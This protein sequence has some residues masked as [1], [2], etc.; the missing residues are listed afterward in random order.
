MHFRTTACATCRKLSTLL[1]S[2][3]NSSRGTEDQVRGFCTGASPGQAF[4]QR[5]HL[6]FKVTLET[7]TRGTEAW[8]AHVPA[9]LAGRVQ[10]GCTSVPGDVLSH[11]AEHQITAWTPRHVESHVF[12]CLPTTHGCWLPGSMNRTA[13]RVTSKLS[14]RFADILKSSDPSSFWSSLPRYF[15]KAARDH[16]KSQQQIAK[17][18]P[19]EVWF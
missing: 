5:P 7:Q 6:H 4:I 12:G 3:S 8:P 11:L 1:Q 10:A 18:S 17:P 15:T 9:L 19:S 2:L 14:T 13:Q 16:K